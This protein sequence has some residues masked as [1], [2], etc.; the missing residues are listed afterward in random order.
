MKEHN[1]SRCRRL[2]FCEGKA[3]DKPNRCRGENCKEQK[4]SARDWKIGIG[5][6]PDSECSS[7]CE[8]REGRKPR[9][10]EHSHEFLSRRTSSEKLSAVILLPDHLTQKENDRKTNRCCN[11]T[12]ASPLPFD[13][14][15][16]SGNETRKRATSGK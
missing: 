11:Q 13:C 1:Q 8:Q 16:S 9:L 12:R 6:N 7:K 14:Q 10:G 4:S 5:D 3:R 15:S 2:I